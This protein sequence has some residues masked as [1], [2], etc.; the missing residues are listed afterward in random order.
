[1]E[2]KSFQNNLPLSFYQEYYQEV[3]LREEAEDGHSY[4]V[5]QNEPQDRCSSFGLFAKLYYF[6]GNAFTLLKFKPSPWKCKAQCAG[7]WETHESEPAIPARRTWPPHS[8]QVL[9]NFS[10]EQQATLV[11]TWES[12]D[13]GLPLKF[14]GLLCSTIKTIHNG[15]T[16]VIAHILFYCDFGSSQ[17]LQKYWKLLESRMLSCVPSIP[18]AQHDTWWIINICHLKFWLS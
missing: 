14:C 3:L 9:I 7:R 8:A 18:R 5:K 16:S 13:C 11:T 12:N 17:V 15:Y 1:M 10:Q 6:L 2:W 4:I